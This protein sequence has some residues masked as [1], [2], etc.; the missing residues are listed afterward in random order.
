MGCEHIIKLLGIIY[1]I[2]HIFFIQFSLTP[3]KCYDLAYDAEFDD[4]E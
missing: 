3:E 1:L 4:C 2:A